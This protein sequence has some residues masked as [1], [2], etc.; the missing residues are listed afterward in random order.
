MAAGGRSQPT[1]RP[2]AQHG[3]D[4]GMQFHDPPCAQTNS[5]RQPMPQPNLSCSDVRAGNTLL[6]A[7]IHQLVSV[8]VFGGDSTLQSVLFSLLLFDGSSC[9]PRNRRPTSSGGGF[10]FRVATRVQRRK[11]LRNRI[12]RNVLA[13][14][15]R[16]LGSYVYYASDCGM[17]SAFTSTLKT[18]SD[19]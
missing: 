8:G 14:S 3:C 4:S 12:R 10:L 11:P 5:R 19:P 2:V 1:Q 6:D 9:G 13:L 17:T 18:P 15:R 7:S 16:C